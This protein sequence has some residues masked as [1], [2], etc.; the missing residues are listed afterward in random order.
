MAK[1]IERNSKIP[2][3]ASQTFTTYSDNQPAV[4]IQ[5]FEGERAMT[6][7]NNNLG[8][9]DLT[10]I[11]PAPRGVPQIE[12]E[13]DIDA[14]GILNVSAHDKSTGNTK[15]ITITNDRGRLSKDDIDRM[16]SE[17]EKYKEEDEKQKERVVARNQLENYIFSVKQAVGDSGDKLSNDDKDN[18]LKACD[19]SLKWLDNIFFL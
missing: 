7:D 2:T 10:G 14:N 16:V 19:E 12:V 3:K 4:N 18:V 15:K 8:R 9:F 1:L 13:F 11:P 17:A 5:V 6:K